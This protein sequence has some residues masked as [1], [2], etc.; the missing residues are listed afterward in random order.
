MIELDTVGIGT[1]PATI[2]KMAALEEAG[3]RTLMIDKSSRVGGNWGTINLPIVGEVESG[4]HYIGPDP[5]FYKLLESIL[6]IELFEVE[7]AEYFL[8]RKIFFS[9]NSSYLSRW[10]SGVSPPL[11]KIPKNIAEFRSTFGPYLRCI[12]NQLKS[13][14]KPSIKMKYFCGGTPGFVVALW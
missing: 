10:G 9:H 5:I 12:Q 1:S 2:F 14:G 6:G 3:Q 11:N 8:P 4:A 7:R 13:F